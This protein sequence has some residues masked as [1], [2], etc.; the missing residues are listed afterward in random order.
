M[1]KAI[2]IGLIAGGGQ[3]PVLFA[4]AAKRD[5]FSVVAIGF[6]NETEENLALEADHF[7]L[8]NP[9]QLGKLISFLKKHDVKRI[10][11]AGHI[12]KSRFYSNIKLDWRA[13]KFITKLR[14]RNDDSILRAFARELEKEGITVEPST[15]FLPSL[16]APEGV[17]SERHPT[18]RELEDIIFGWKIAKAIGK[19]DIGQCVVVK[20]KSVIAVEG[21]DGTDETIL[22]GG[23]LC[24]SGAVVVK[25]SKPIQ[26]LRF[27]VPSVGLKTI[28]TMKRVG[29]TTLAIEA[30]K[31]L[32]FDKEDML[33][34]AKEADIAV[35]S[36]SNEKSLLSLKEA[37]KV[38]PFLLFKPSKRIKIG[39]V[40]VGYLGKFHVEKFLK[41]RVVTLVGVVDV[42]KE[43]LD[44]ISKRFNVNCF[45]SHKELIGKVDGVSI[46]T[47]S[48][49]HFR[50]AKDFI[51]AG[52]HVFIEKPMTLNVEEAKYLVELAKAK[53]VI[54]QVGHIERFNPAFKAVLPF[55]KK[56]FLI[57]AKRF[58]EFKNRSAEVD[59]VMDMMIHDIDIVLT[60]EKSP[61]KALSAMGVSV[62]T[63]S[64][65][66]A[67]VRLEFESGTVANLSASRVF[68]EDVRKMEI[69][70]EDGS[71]LIDYHQRRA[72][73]SLYGGS[74]DE[75]EVSDEDPLEE[76]LKNFVESI[77][78]RKEPVVSGASAYR[79]IELAS[80]IS[81]AIR[82]NRNL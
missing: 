50:I 6:E 62:V 77:C 82:D 49:E 75:I 64:I 52:V 67:S 73:K 69:F 68:G 29:A 5:G 74:F 70:Q 18:E 39:V 76:E 20:H 42:L 15:L 63:N 59:V 80:I 44:D 60:F 46:V 71:I 38:S 8:I 37:T 25:V 43:R 36:I 55:I 1:D 34:A 28:E 32:L 14:N 22:R 54:L 17:L 16:V 45:T 57:E 58:S 31:T 2:T 4:R 26:D 78:Y 53:G 51:E 12:N 30:G 19:L 9:G 48:A 10:A 3:F 13:F 56:P 21:I 65:D 35:V 72:F 33:K 11:L 41:D 79:A 27:D 81:K 66:V 40:G 47:S 7:Y 23:R 24:G 61:V